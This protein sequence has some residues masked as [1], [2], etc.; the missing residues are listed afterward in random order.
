MSVSLKIITYIFAAFPFLFVYFGIT[1]N[2]PVLFLVSLFFYLLMV[3]VWLWMRPSHY[4][5]DRRALTIVWPLRKYVVLRSSIRNIRILDKHQIKEELGF[6][7]RIG[8]GGLF[9][10]IGLL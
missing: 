6:A 1:V 10:G 9:G 7:V 3:G 4:I 2:L 5:V 8:V